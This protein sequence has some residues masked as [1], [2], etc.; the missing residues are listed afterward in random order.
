MVLVLRG[1]HLLAQAHPQVADVREIKIHVEGIGSPS[2]SE[3]LIH[4]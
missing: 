3:E 4:C 2:V 1:P